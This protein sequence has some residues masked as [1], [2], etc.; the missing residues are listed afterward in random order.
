M[1]RVPF[2]GILKCLYLKWDKAKAAFEV[3]QTRAP[4]AAALI[5]SW[6]SQPGRA[7]VALINSQ[8]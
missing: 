3:P 4:G 1:G 7:K 2:H 6:V 8:F 5:S